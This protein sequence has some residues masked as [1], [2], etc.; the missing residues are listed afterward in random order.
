[1][2]ERT[3]DTTTQKRVLILDT[4]DEIRERL[5]YIQS[6]RNLIVA[7]NE[8]VIKYPSNSELAAEI[9]ETNKELI[10]RYTDEIR[11]I[12]RGEIKP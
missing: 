10:D 2:V 1:M 9:I 11:R 5:S 12:Q 7:T 8:S 6:C 4:K 3:E